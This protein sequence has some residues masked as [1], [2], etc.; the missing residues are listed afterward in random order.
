MGAREHNT[1]AAHL[2]APAHRTTLPQRTTTLYMTTPLHH[3][4][5]CSTPLHH[6]AAPHRCTTPLHHTAAPP[7]CTTPL[8]HTAALHHTQLHACMHPR[9]ASTHT[10][11]AERGQLVCLRASLGGGAPVVQHETCADS[12][13]R[14]QVRI[15]MWF[16]CG[17]AVWFGCTVWLYGV[18]VRCGCAV[19][20]RDLRGDKTFTKRARCMYSTSWG[21]RV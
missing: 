19:W 21:T 13:R 1:A 4:A 7:R 12:K 3:T 9:V 2:I 10:Y 20:L 16:G 17:L 11:L 6:T 18:A 5:R 15:N 8:H 14:F